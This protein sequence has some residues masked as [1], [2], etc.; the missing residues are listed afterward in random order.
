MRR[1]QQADPAAAAELVRVLSPM[2]LRFLSG[3]AQTRVH[4]EDMLQEC[5]LRIHKAR[6]TYRQDA[7]VLPW[8]R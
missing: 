5:W 2:L 7:P 6:H 3:P 1:Y 8:I 4:A